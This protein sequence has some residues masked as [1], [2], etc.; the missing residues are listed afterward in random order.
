MPY[1]FCKQQREKFQKKNRNKKKKKAKPE[2]YTTVSCTIDSTYD[3]SVS[4]PYDVRS[5]TSCSFKQR[6]FNQWHFL[7]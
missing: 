7:D 6:L 2:P 1:F 5:C 4:D 3:A